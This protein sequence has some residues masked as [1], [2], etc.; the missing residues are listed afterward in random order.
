MR[1]F[2]KGF[3][4]ASEKKV[5]RGGD[6]TR[7]EGGAGRNYERLQNPSPY[8]SLLNNLHLPNQSNH[9]LSPP[10]PL[11]P[12]HSVDSTLES[13]EN[14]TQETV[15]ELMRKKNEV[16]RLMKMEHRHESAHQIGGRWF[17]YLDKF[18]CGEGAFLNSSGSVHNGCEERE[19]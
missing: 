10:F 6:G 9:R 14:P 13:P 12:L 4:E 19:V 2:H 5:E 15:E 11:P 18:N 17:L 3:V 16:A 1:V 8:I 7:E